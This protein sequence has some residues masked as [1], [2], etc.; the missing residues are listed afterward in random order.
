M[1][2]IG[3]AAVIVGMARHPGLDLHHLISSE[4]QISIL[5]VHGPTWPHLR[6][7]VGVGAI[8]ILKTRGPKWHNVISL[9]AAGVFNS[10][11]YIELSQE[12]ETLVRNVKQNHKIEKK[13]HLPNHMFN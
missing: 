6:S 2:A 11:L 9:K 4:G 13:N 1:A 7:L 12:L 3:W 5:K 10:C 8:S